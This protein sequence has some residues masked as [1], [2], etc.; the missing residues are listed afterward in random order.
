MEMNPLLIPAIPL[1]VLVFINLGVAGW[2][3]YYL[4]RRRFILRWR[5]VREDALALLFGFCAFAIFLGL[6]IGF[7][8]FESS[9]KLDVLTG[10]AGGLKFGMTGILA[11]QIIIVF[12]L[13][14][15]R[16]RFFEKS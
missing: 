3:Y 4:S 16:R 11:G 13:T 6:M 7:E 14:S 5:I 1:Y 15:L 12:F 10:L 2:L 8:A 9:P